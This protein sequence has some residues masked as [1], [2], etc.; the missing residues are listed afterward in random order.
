MVF[1]HCSILIQTACGSSHAMEIPLKSF[2]HLCEG[3]A[4]DLRGRRCVLDGEIVRLDANGKPQLCDLLF[5][6]AEP[7]FYAFR[8]A[9]LAY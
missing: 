2:P 4:H 9:D 5:R 8:D 7:V 6:R 1:G 3:L